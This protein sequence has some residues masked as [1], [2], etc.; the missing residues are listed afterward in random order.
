VNTACYY[1]LVIAST[2]ACISTRE[3]KTACGHVILPQ[4][5]LSNG[6]A[7][8]AEMDSPACGRVRIG[9]E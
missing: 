4:Q 3:L 1:I 7:R 8:P 9:T 2:S 6:L 5:H